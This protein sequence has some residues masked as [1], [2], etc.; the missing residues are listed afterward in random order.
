MEESRY[1]R[2]VR[3]VEAQGEEDKEKLDSDMHQGRSQTENR[4]GNGRQQQEG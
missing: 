3:V 2:V 4:Q 1:L